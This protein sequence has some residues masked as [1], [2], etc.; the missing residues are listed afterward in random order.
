MNAYLSFLDWFWRLFLAQSVI[1]IL[2][3]MSLISFSLPMSD[4]NRPYFIL[5]AIYYWAI[6]RPTLILPIF[7]FCMGLVFDLVVGFPLGLHSILFLL[8]QLV[9]RNQRLFFMGQTYLVVWMGFTLTCFLVLT[10]EWLF[11][12]AKTGEWVTL[13]PIVSSFLLT[14]LSFPLVTL[15]FIS[16]HRLLPV[17]PKSVL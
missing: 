7:V 4:E 14:L 2:F 10:S 6:Y 12:S 3:V 11:F 17:A 5:M 9:I 1:F 13:K 8:V 15:L 16:V